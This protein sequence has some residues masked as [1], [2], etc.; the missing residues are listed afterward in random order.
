MAE[1]DLIAA[2]TACPHCRGWP[3][4]PGDPDLCH[5]HPDPCCPEETVTTWP[6]PF[7][8][9]RYCV[10]SGRPVRR[11]GDRCIKH[12]AA[13]TMCQTDVRP[14]QCSHERQSPN[15]PYPHCSECGADAAP[16]ATGEDT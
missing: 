10:D 11:A 16:G 5:E 13:D 1:P 3:H 4:E 2:L 7:G 9:E 12:G 14:A 6:Y 8:D 15:H